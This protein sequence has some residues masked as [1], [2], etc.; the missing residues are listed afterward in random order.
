VGPF[1]PSLRAGEFVDW[2]VRVVASGARVVDIDDLV[3]RRRVHLASTTATQARAADRGDYLE[4]V[5]RWMK[6]NGS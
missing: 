2:F 1:D 5:R 4:V 3:L 6:Q